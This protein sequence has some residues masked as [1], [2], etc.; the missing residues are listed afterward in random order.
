MSQLL[1]CPHHTQDIPICA[2]QTK[3]PLFQYDDYV[4]CSTL[5]EQQIRKIMRYTGVD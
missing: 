4:I 5:T 3:C 2:Y 1:P